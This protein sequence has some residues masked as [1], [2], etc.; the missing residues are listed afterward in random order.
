MAKEVSGSTAINMASAPIANAPRPA[1]V[2][3]GF[4]LPDGPQREY[5]NDKNGTAS[6]KV[7]VAN[8]K[9]AGSDIGFKVNINLIR[10]LD[11]SKKFL[12]VAMPFNGRQSIFE[13]KTD[14]GKLAIATFRENTATEFRAWH[15]KL[16]N[17]AAL[18]TTAPSTATTSS[19]D[20]LL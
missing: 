16:A 1:F 15:A 8:V 11:G 18:G 12:R 6:T 17:V 9:I 14:A 4:A 2:L 20:V 19:G 10:A 13:G 5:P 7:G 3:D